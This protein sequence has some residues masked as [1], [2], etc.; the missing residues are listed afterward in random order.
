MDKAVFLDRDGVINRKAPEGEYVTSWE[1][2]H[3]LPGVAQAVAVLNR[4]GFKVII[5]SNQRCVAKGLLSISELESM[6]RRVTDWLLDQ[7]A[8]IDA[9]YYCPHEKQPPCCCRKPSPGMLL[10]AASEHDIDLSA[11]WMIG[12]SDSDVNAGRN[13]GCRTARV[14][15]HEGVIAVEADIVA[16]SLL[17]AVDQLLSWE[18]TRARQEVHK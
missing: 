7:G 12:D 1:D 13:A 9:I 4:H 14:H 6:H 11:S 8:A 16:S 17:E 18:N 10:K 15:G 2:M 3:F 5:V